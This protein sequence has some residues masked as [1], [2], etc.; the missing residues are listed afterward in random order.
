MTK[1]YREFWIR[2]SLWLLAL[3]LFLAINVSLRSWFFEFR[4]YIRT[5]ISE[6]LGPDD[7]PT[8]PPVSATLIISMAGTAVSTIGTLT[9]IVL[10]IRKDR[11]ESNLPKPETP[12]PKKKKKGR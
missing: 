2:L 9:T 6:L 1:P 7:K 11:R 10:G 8:P 3:G 5:H 4:E 12:A